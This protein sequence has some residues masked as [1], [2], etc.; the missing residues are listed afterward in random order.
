MNTQDTIALSALFVALISAL[1]AFIYW[2]MSLSYKVTKF[3]F[4]L[5]GHVNELLR[6]MAEIKHISHSNQ[7]ELDGMVIR[8]NYLTKIMSKEFP[9]YFKRNE[10]KI[11]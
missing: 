10:D 6:D 4:E 7:R 2:L 11:E 3:I 1:A 8:L 9:E 5:N